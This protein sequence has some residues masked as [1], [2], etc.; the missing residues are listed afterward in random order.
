MILVNNIPVL[1]AR[2]LNRNYLPM[3]NNFCAVYQGRI[4]RAQDF[5]LWVEKQRQITIKVN[6]DLKVAVL[7]QGKVVPPYQ[8]NSLTDVPISQ[9]SFRTSSTGN[10]LVSVRGMTP[11]AKITFCLN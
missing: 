9:Y 6:S 3:K 7:F 10:H 8:V 11:D 2:Q 1:A 4:D 5:P